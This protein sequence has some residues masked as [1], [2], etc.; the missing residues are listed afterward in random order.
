MKVSKVTVRKRILLVFVV[1]IVLYASLITRLGYV[2]IIQG[3]W[4]KE[5]AE[6]LWSRNLPFEPKRGRILDRNGEVLAYNVSVP[7]VMAIPAQVTDPAGTARSLA[8]ILGED[9]Q[10]VY[11]AITKKELM[12]SIPGGRKISEEKARRVQEL[13]LP[14]ITIMED[15]KRYYP[16]GAFASHVL[17]FTGIDNQGLTGIE[18]VYDEG[19]KGERGHISFYTDARG[20]RMPGQPERYNPPKN[21]MDLELTIDSQIQAVLER[22][23]DQAEL[24]YQPD[25][26]LAIAMDPNS[27]AILGMASRPNYDPA[28]YQDYPSDI[29]N[30][31]LPIWKTYE[32]GSTFKIITLAAALEENKVDLDHDHFYDPGYI[33]VADAQLRCWKR[34]GHGS[35]SYLEVVENSCNPGFVALGQSLGKDVLFDYIHKFGFGQKTGIDLI[36]EEN[37]VL[38]KKNRVGPVELGTTA[39]GQGVSV[40]PIQQVTAVSAAINGGKL[41][42][43]YVARRWYS[44]Q[45]GET[46]DIQQP[47]VVRQVISPETSKEVRRALESV[48]AK[49]TGRNAYI[50]GYRVGGKTGTAQVVENGVY[51]R[52]K[53]IVSFIGFA[54]AD[55]PQIVIY[56]AVNNPKGTVQFGGT[57][58]APLVKN[59]LDSSLRYLE[60]PPRKEQMEKEYRY[61]IDRK[62]VEVPNFIG[63]ETRSLYGTYYTFSVDIDGKGD[64][65]IYQSPEPGT[66]VEEGATIR[67]Y[68]GESTGD[69]IENGD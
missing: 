21:G 41:Y 6:D 39:F 32:P 18:K 42:K 12:V 69:K 54:P 49:G 24:V 5:H 29:F 43:P 46:I 65:V 59:I 4:L 13:N 25:D 55:D 23:L 52:S 53:H 26:I 47:Q 22:E 19:L 63:R 61:G 51:S 58:A 64:V 7:S 48:V 38:F 34:G 28:N 50:D 10:S 68:L 9:E 66:R 14:G 2:Q 62:L 11:R 15:S 3:S 16:K 40:T 31:N 30:R 35:Q 60:V 8:T 45:T 56:L 67:L 17:G 37:G 36:G 44:P 1:G 57:V 27:G 20:N 33:K